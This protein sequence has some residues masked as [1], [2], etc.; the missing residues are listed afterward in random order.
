[1]NVIDSTKIF[2]IDN[3]KM[4]FYVLSPF[5]ASEQKAEIAIEIIIL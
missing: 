3:L 1:M 4:K 5:A 2:T